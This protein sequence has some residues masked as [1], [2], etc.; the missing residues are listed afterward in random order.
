[1]TFY[2]IPYQSSVLDVYI[3]L[4]RID[5]SDIHNNNME[6]DAEVE[7]NDA[8]DSAEE[9]GLEGKNSLLCFF[10]I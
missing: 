6:A 9:L 7:A 2:T 3:P 1:M 5:I 8:D 10:N 4:T